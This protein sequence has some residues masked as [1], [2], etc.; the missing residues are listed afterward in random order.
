M[1]TETGTAPTTI[2]YLKE[3]L[4]AP[5]QHPEIL[6]SALPLILGGVA[7]ELY[8]G[9]HKDERLGWNSSL[10]NAV[11]WVATGLTLIV[12]GE[13]TSVMHRYVAY[14]LIGLGG[15]TGYMDFYHKWP[16][17]VAF[18]ASSAISVYSVAYVTLVM[19][20]TGMPVTTPSLKAA[21]IFIVGA[22]LFF[23]AVQLFETSMD[24][25]R[26]GLPN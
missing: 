2:Q 6:P 20:K 14:F 17:E 25:S 3:I 9:K 24:D 18:V 22:T 19:V 23:Q 10:A 26:K 7:L 21:G 4:Y 15:I 11:I 12:S 8:F 13:I 1:I 5:Y 16:E